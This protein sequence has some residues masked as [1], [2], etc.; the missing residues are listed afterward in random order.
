MKQERKQKVL[1]S[2]VNEVITKF[3]EKQERGWLPHCSTLL[4]QPKY[5][6]RKK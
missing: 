4:H 5:P 3:E 1:K 2:V 6:R